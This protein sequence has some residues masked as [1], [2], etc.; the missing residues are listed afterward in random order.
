MD[1]Y[2]SSNVKQENEQ[3]NNQI[4]DLKNLIKKNSEIIDEIKLSLEQQ[5]KQPQISLNE[6][7]TDTQSVLG[8]IEQIENQLGELKSELKQRRIKKPLEAHDFG[9]VTS[10]IQRGETIEPLKDPLDLLE[11]RLDN[12]I[13]TINQAQEK[14][15]LQIRT[16]NDALDILGTGVEELHRI[17]ETLRI[18][19]NHN[20]EGISENQYRNM[21]R[22]LVDEIKIDQKLLFENFS[23]IIDDYR[24]DFRREMTD[25]VKEFQA[26]HDRILNDVIANYVPRNAGDELRQSIDIL[27]NEF[28]YELDKLRVKFEAV[29]QYKD[30]QSQLRQDI[31]SIIDR[32][33]NERF[34][35]ISILL[36]TITS[37]TEKIFRLFKASEIQTSPSSNEIV[38]TENKLAPDEQNTEF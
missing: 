17:I 32:A 5:V 14:T 13:D 2:R 11:T 35:A 24:S 36:A 18:R 34:N 7:E 8:R 22:E 1:F 38:K 33:V 20:K 28:K 21:V 15:T 4:Q 12:K 25:T 27:S 16:L 9:R 6:V 19:M 31:T 26:S 10:A 37:K 23:K 30:S 3:K 29:D